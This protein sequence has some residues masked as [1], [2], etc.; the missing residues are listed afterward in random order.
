MVAMLLALLLVGAGAA[1]VV[2]LNPFGK[3]KGGETPAGPPTVQYGS[4][5][6]GV[7]IFDHGLFVGETPV[8]HEIET[9][10]PDH[11]LQIVTGSRTLNVTVP[12]FE[13]PSWIYVAVPPEPAAALGWAVIKTD[14]PGA[15]VKLGGKPVGKTP[16]VYLGVAEDE[17]DLEVATEEVSAR[18][19]AKLGAAGVTVDV[20]LE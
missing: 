11:E 7:E 2:I 3:G 17:L 14:P 20:A 16:L 5:P 13:G 8:L 19:K 15:D 4:E 10:R 6:A 12:A 18:S 1:A 9:K